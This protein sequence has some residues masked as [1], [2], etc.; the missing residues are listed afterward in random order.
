MATMLKL[1]LLLRVNA[2]RAPQNSI[3]P[4]TIL[5]GQLSAISDKEHF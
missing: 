2:V 3:T 1:R 4:S 5:A